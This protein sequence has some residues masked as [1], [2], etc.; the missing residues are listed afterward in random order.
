M[1]LEAIQA[2]TDE[3]IQ[4]TE[5]LGKEAL[6]NDIYDFLVEIAAA[7]G[8]FDKKELD[9]MMT[10]T[11]SK[12]RSEVI[13]DVRNRI[14][15]GNAFSAVIPV[16]YA[17]IVDKENDNGLA[18]GDLPSSNEMLLFF[19][20][21]GLNFMAADG[22]SAENEVKLYTAYMDRLKEYRTDLAHAKNNEPQMSNVTETIKLSENLPKGGTEHARTSRSDYYGEKWRKEPAAKEPEMDPFAELDSLIGM[23]NVKE[24]VASMINFSKV[25]KLREERGLS[26]LPVSLHVVFTGNPGTGKTT[27]AKLI[28]QMYAEIGV[29]EDGHLVEVSEADLVDYAVGGTP[30]KTMKKIEEAIGGVLFIDEAYSLAKDAS[31]NH[32]R[33]A[34]ETLLKQMEDRRGEFMVIA[35]GYPEPMTKFLFS[36]PGLR[37]RFSRTIEFSDYTGDEL[38]KIF[39]S[40]CREGQLSVDKKTQTGLQRHFYQM[41]QNR[42]KNFAN[43]RDVRNYFEKTVMAQ[44]N[45]LGG[46]KTVA[47]TDL[48]RLMPEDLG[49][50]E[51]RDEEKLAGLLAELDALPG[52]ARV[53]SEL[54]GII[55]HIRIQQERDAAGLDTHKGSLHMIF[56][57]NPGT[58]KTTVARLLGKILAALGVL[59]EGQFVEKDRGGLVAG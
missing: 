52:L 48:M 44:S 55:N 34:I 1:T 29:L 13:K 51:D 6:V 24:E 21:I 58:G 27:V 30:M 25:Q 56:T 3:M 5:A 42:D 36:N 31:V 37:S 17:A 4:R 16:T 28:G 49:L 53:K 32:G 38:F 26:P 11:G 14:E 39:A 23:K 15:Q 41:Y 10:L 7:D 43:G 47:V 54:A 22:I 46:Q 35:A 45:R 57:G 8:R 19:E 40:M 33:E 9:I 50:S 12:L 59:S 2:K 18:T 20:M